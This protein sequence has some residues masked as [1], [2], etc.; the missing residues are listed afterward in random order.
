MSDLKLKNSSET[1]IIKFFQSTNRI[2][3]DS[4]VSL[5]VCNSIMSGFWGKV[6][7]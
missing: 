1:F 6:D 5:Y 2:N 3:L 4:I 7:T